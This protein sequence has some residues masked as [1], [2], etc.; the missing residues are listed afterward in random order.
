MILLTEKFDFWNPKSLH[1]KVKNFM[2]K[3]IKF[4]IIVGARPNFIKIA[5]LF[6]EF[7]KHKE[8]KLVLVHT[9]QH[10]DYEMS[11]IFF[12]DLK[13]PKPNYNL[14][15]GSGSHVWQTAKTMERLEPIILKE[16]PQ[17][18]IVIGDVNSTLAG[19]LVAI[20]LK[21][22]IAH[23]EAGPR[24]F[25]RLMPEEINRKLTER[26]ADFLFCPT[27]TAVLNLKKEGFKNINITYVGDLMYDSFLNGEKIASK[28]SKILSELKLRPRQYILLTVHRSENVDN[29]DSLKR[30]MEAMGEINEKVVFPVHPR[31]QK[32]LNLLGF[33]KTM[34]NIRFIDPVGYIDM[35]WLEKNAK[36]II[37]DSGGIQKEAYWSRVSCITLMETS[38]W[39]ET[40]RDGWN[41]LAGNNKEKIIKAVKKTSSQK[42]Q[43]KYF[44]DG[45]A[46]KKIVEILIKHNQ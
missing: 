1:V 5:P 24:S 21:I 25:N 2:K 9:G 46:T 32:A 17:M 45:K 34:S 13:I 16:K 44:G 22:A 39:P 41:I 33:C 28:K 11:Q 31:T 18:V 36:K 20:K 19:A 26:T 7:K 14:E 10:Y 38:G 23:I 6:K 12:Q 40:V 4:L 15:I 43:Y 29:L 8:V 37:T 27:K 42:K 30:I 35:L 3:Q